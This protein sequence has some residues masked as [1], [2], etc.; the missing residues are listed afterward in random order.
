MRPCVNISP[1]AKP[2]PG[3]NVERESK[4]AWVRNPWGDVYEVPRGHNPV[5]LVQLSLHHFACHVTSDKLPY[6]AESRTI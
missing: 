6:N 4:R 2:N 1:P 5:E 3:E